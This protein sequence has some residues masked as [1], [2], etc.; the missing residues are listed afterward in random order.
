MR[1]HVMS[2]HLPI[3]F[4]DN[5]LQDGELHTKRMMALQWLAERCGVESLPDLRDLINN[6]ND[7]F[8]IPQDCYIQEGENI[9]LGRSVRWRG[10][11]F[12]M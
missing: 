7:R 8:I 5:A 10:G 6:S 3:R 1:K 11:V 4:R 2:R 9:G 12:H